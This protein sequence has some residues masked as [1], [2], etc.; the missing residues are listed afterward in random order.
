MS[1]AK[2]AKPTLGGTRAIRQRKRNIQVKHDPEAFRDALFEVFDG[3][4]EVSD[5]KK[6]MQSLD[7]ESFDYSRYGEV[8]AEVMIAGNIVEPGGSLRGE[9]LPICVFTAPS[10]E[11][12]Y[13]AVEILHQMMRRKPFL[14]ARYDTVVV[15][16]QLF[17][18][19]Y[20]PEARQ[21]FACTVGLMMSRA[22]LTPSVLKEIGAESNVEGN[23]ALDFMTGVI[24]E[25]LKENENNATKL[26]NLLRA[27]GMDMEAIVNLMPSKQRSAEEL[28]RYFERLGLEKLVEENER[29][30]R[31][32]KVAD[33]R[34]GVAEQVAEGV[35]NEETAE[36]VDQKCQKTSVSDVDRVIAV[37]DG[38]LESVDLDRKAQQNRVA[39]LTALKVNS[40]LLYRT[41]KGGK[42]EVVLLV[43]IQNYVSNDMELLKIGAF[44]DIVYVLYKEDVFGEDTILRWFRRGTTLVKGTAASSNIIREQMQ[45]FVDWLEN[46]EEET[47]VAA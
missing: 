14:R 43:Q 5:M 19:S 21:N 7:K 6:V 33:V 2:E 41:C 15:K 40:P 12:V 8:F 26:M 37:W 17:L 47:P 29:R 27:A 24:Q 31:Q 11:Q 16:L 18:P 10:S 32:L 30:V 13:G 35:P 38:I 22:M 44:R 36:W 34:S 42:D 4:L 9:A 25:F 46:A 39:L 28:S 23:F 1:S 45:P 3:E 20:T